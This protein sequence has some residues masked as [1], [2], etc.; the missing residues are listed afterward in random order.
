MPRVKR[1]STEAHLAVKMTQR[2]ISK[3]NVDL[4]RDAGYNPAADATH[5]CSIE[6]RIAKIMTERCNGDTSCPHC[7]NATDPK[8]RCRKCNNTRDIY[9]KK[10]AKLQD[11]AEKT[12]DIYKMR[13][14]IK[15]DPRGSTLYIQPVEADTTADELQDAVSCSRI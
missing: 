2:L 15:T 4:N 11:L 1:V 10:L 14:V 9:G 7:S 5:L 12:A 3:L 8:R 13:A 6:S